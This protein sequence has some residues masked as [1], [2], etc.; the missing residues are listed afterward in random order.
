M[1]GIGHFVE[2]TTDLDRAK[3]RVAMSTEASM[4]GFAPSKFP[5]NIHVNVAGFP[6]HAGKSDSA[7]C[8][9]MFTAKTKKLTEDGNIAHVRYLPAYNTGMSENINIVVFNT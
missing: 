2:I 4:L 8:I 3:K 7:S 1:I 9:V 6:G 5:K